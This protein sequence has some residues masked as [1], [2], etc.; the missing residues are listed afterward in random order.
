MKDVTPSLV[1]R[2]TTPRLLLREPRVADFDA[3]A[4]H[5]SDPDANLYIGGTL[6]RRRAWTAFASL[7]GQWMITGAGWWAIEVRETG[8][9]IGLVGAFFRETSLPVGPKTDIEVGWNLFQAYWGKGYAKEAAR[10]ALTFACERHHV[11]RAI[12]HITPANVA[13]VAVAQAIGMT[14][15]GEVD[16][17]G[18]TLSRYV[19]SRHAHMD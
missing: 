4:E 7:S 15:E 3:Y 12:A 10:T 14:Y 8:A 5:R 6:D 11:R 17:Y 13:S 18:E 1:E 16:F 9:F 19:S 2:I